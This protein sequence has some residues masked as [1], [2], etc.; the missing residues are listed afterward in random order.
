M[1]TWA[2]VNLDSLVN[3][4]LVRKCLPRQFPARRRFSGPLAAVEGARS[5][6]IDSADVANAA[7]ITRFDICDAQHALT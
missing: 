2:A 5:G 6:D 7:D 1:L 3:L 4:P